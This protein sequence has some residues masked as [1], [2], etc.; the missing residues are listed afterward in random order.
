MLRSKA[1]S[2]EISLN[3]LARVLLMINKKRGYKSSRKGETDTDIEDMGAYLAAISGRSNMLVESHQTV[4]QYLM[5]QLN[6]HPLK[7]IKRQTFYRKDYEDEFEKCLE[8]LLTHREIA[9]Q[10]GRNGGEYVRAH[11]AWDVIVRRYREYFDRIGA[12][13]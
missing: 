10:M 5:N 7:G 9:N 6:L 13:A 3:E 1:A 8:Y 4:G 11:F 12:E 2:E